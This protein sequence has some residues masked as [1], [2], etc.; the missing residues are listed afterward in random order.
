LANDPEFD[1]GGVAIVFQAFGYGLAMVLANLCYLTFGP[2][3]ESLVKPKKPIPYRRFFFLLGTVFSAALP[4]G[5][6]LLVAVGG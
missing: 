4:F 3:L 5:I 6:P 2:G 1:P